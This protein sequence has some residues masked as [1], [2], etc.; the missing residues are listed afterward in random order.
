MLYAKGNAM[1]SKT[2]LSLFQNGQLTLFLNLHFL[3]KPFY[4]LSY[5]A[6]AKTNGLFHLLSAKPVPF[7]QLAETYCADNGALDALEAWLQLGIRLNLLKLDKRGYS[8]RGLSR[9][10]ALQENDAL[11]ALA[12]EVTTLHYNLIIKTPEKLKKGSLWGLEDQDGELIARSS[13]SLEPFQTEA[14]DKTFPSSGAVRLLEIGCGSGFYIHYAASRNPSL[15]ALG[16][17]LQPNVAEMARRN[18][19]GWGLQDRVKIES[20]DIRD[21]EPS[22]LFDIVTLYNNIYYFPVQDRVS[23]LAWI[24]HKP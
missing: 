23:F 8:L 16:I 13:R 6:S 7:E 2:L 19:Q 14:I 17:E 18:I 10:L 12:Q 20:G 21:R 11:V 4:K 9:K 15:S 1:N 3:L 22:E 24:F 5:L